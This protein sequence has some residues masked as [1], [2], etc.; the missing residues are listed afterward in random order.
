MG[1]IGKGPAFNPLGTG[2]DIWELKVNGDLSSSLHIIH[3][4]RLYCVSA[5]LTK[6]K[7]SSVPGQANC[8][9]RRVSLPYF[10][11]WH[12]WNNGGSDA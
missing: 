1:T 5:N 12:D 2:P 7:D 11:S 3:E 4:R 8:C 10:E 6:T 9:L